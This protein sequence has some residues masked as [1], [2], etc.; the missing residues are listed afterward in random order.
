MQRVLLIAG[1]LIFD[2]GFAQA[3]NIDDIMARFEGQY[4]GKVSGTEVGRP[5]EGVLVMH[6]FVRRIAAPA[7]GQNVVYL[8]Q[9]YGGP[10]GDITRQR[11]FSFEEDN[12]GIVTTAY[13][14]PDGAKYARADA[15]PQR[16][17]DLTPADMYSFPTGCRIRWS[18]DNGQY[19]GTVK[20]ADCR[21]ESRSGRGDVFVD[22][23]YQLSD[24]AYTL[25]E[26]G[27]NES[28]SF[29]F[30]TPAAHVHHRLPRKNLDAE[31][32][33]ILTAFEGAFE[34]RP[35]VDGAGRDNLMIGSLYTQVRRVNLPT[36]G[37]RVMY[38]EFARGGPD[39]DVMRQRIISFDDDPNRP[40]NVMLTYNFPDGEAY[41]G[42][43][44][45]PSKLDGLT[46]DDLDL[47]ETGCELIWRER[48]G[49]LIGSAHRATCHILNERVQAWR[50]VSFEY[51]LDGDSMH[52]W[53]HGYNPEGMF[54]FG[55]QTPLRFPR[56]RNAW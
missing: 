12:Q 9:R 7:F 54:L 27:F 23:V 33:R 5:A 17:N 49:V 4:R 25:F 52:L 39:G 35:V 45:D 34:N 56:I 6:T 2:P 11:V 37:S 47:F 51:M 16:L 38:M 40:S 43:H 42:A 13:D 24:D 14:F 19:A 29:L 28:G 44:K 20:R 26:Q 15:V 21:I 10:E 53:E 30:G 41:R 32:E 22:M 36:F 48:E 46:P 50:H 1:A 55:T 3:S 18:K 8:E 31:A